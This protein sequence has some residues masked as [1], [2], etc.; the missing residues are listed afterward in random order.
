MV[1]SAPYAYQVINRQNVAVPVQYRL[2]QG[3][4][5][6]FQLGRYHA[7]Y[8][9]VID[10]TLTWSTFLGDSADEV[11]EAITV[12]GSGHAYITGYTYSWVYPVT[13]GAYDIS[14]NGGLRDVFVSKLNRDGSGLIYSTFLGGTD[15][16]MARGIAVDTSGNAYV[17]GFTYSSNYPAT[18]GAFD[19]THNGNTDGFVS[20]LNN[21]G[22]DLVYSTFLGGSENEYAWGIAVDTNGNA[23]VTGSTLSS[24]YPVTSGA[25][26]P[27]YNGNKDI[28]VSVLNNNGSGLVYSTFLGGV[29]DDHSYGIA[30]N[31]SGN[32]Y[33]TGSTSSSTYPVTSGAFDETHNG[34]RDAFVSVLNN[35]G[36]GLVYST[37]LGGVNNDYAF[38]I[39]VDISGKAYVAGYTDS[40][41]YPTTSGAHNEAYSGNHDGFV[42]VLNSNGSDLVH[43]TF[44]GGTDY[45]RAKGIAVD[46]SGN[47]YVTVFTRSSNYPTTSGAFDKTFN[48]NWDVVVSVLNSNCSVLIYSTF[49][50]G[51]NYEEPNG[52]AVDP[53]RNAY[54][55]GETNSGNYPSTSGAFDETHDGYKDI[56]VSK[57]NFAPAQPE[58]IYGDSILCVDNEG[59]VHQYTSPNVPGASYYH[60]TVPSDASILSGQ[61]NHSIFVLFDSL[62]GNVSVTASNP[63]GESEPQ[64][65]YVL[66]KHQLNTL[67]TPVSIAQGLDNLIFTVEDQC[68]EGNL[69]Y[70]WTNLTTGE[71]Y[72]ADHTLNLPV[73]DQ[74]TQLQ[75]FVTDELAYTS[76]NDILVLCHAFQ[77]LDLNGDGCNSLEDLWFL[78]QD[79]RQNNEQDPNGDGLVDVRD[80]LFINLDDPTPCP[81]RSLKKPI[82]SSLPH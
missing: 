32:A 34:D 70:E 41:N 80:F 37:F 11:A 71:T 15:T 76:A 20:V 81:A 17:T 69:I 19:E 72:Q 82:P 52:I 55:T 47:V 58:I 60:W 78:C 33:V 10:P 61:G 73:V 27:T 43:S 65:L 13:T 1:W 49:L 51:S 25:F 35:S 12:D 31:T 54:V 16:D 2:F 3:G 59:Y 48:G 6:G 74:N 68:A 40:G 77:I 5:L 39:A 14:Y 29:G 26:D 9:L 42:S 24:T 30:V 7:D 57:I 66:V 63:I 53:S 23:Y 79:W 28:F 75:V 18:S 67:V 38:G 50:G 4:K 36:S 46:T 56:F 8:P 21:N 64:H 22:S 62:S 45:D 44:L